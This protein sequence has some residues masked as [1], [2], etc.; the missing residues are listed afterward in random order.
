M[1]NNR[2]NSR[3]S[4]SIPVLLQ[5][6]DSNVFESWGIIFDI[7]QGG[8]KIE[9]PTELSRNQL[10]YLSFVVGNK[11]YFKNVQGLV[12]RVLLEGH[13]YLMGIKFESVKDKELLDSAINFL[14]SE[15]K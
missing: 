6:P 1:I 3:I 5:I 7:S 13:S 12:I 9:T 4:C 8:V 10:I 2:R 15:S 11:Y 14:K